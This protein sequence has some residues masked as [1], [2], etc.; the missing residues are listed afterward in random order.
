MLNQVIKSRRVKVND[1]AHY[2]TSVQVTKILSR[3]RVHRYGRAIYQ[4]VIVGMA[5]KENGLK[6]VKA[7]FETNDCSTQ[8]YAITAPLT[9]REIS[10]EEYLKLRFRK[11]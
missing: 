4:H 2:Y 7:V 11:G 6:P 9:W 5:A 1:Y 3:E 10:Q 8:E